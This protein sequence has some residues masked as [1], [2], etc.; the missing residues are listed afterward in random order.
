MTGCVT[1]RCRAAVPRLRGTTV[2]R[3]AWRS[4][5]LVVAVVALAPWWGEPSTLNLLVRFMSLLCLAQMWNL[6]AGYAGLVSIGQQAFIGI[7]AYTLVYFGNERGLNIFLLRA[8]R[9]RRRGRHR[10]AARRR[11]CSACAAATSRSAR[12]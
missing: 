12:G 1:L 10:A 6:L 8:A 3:V 2:S 9:R 5:S 7:G 11:W 4:G